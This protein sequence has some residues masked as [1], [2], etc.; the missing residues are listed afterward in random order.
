MNLHN[1]KI[2]A[3]GAKDLAEALRTLPGVPGPAFLEIKVALGSRKDLGRP[4]E[5]PQENK[6]GFM[7]YLQ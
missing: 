1:N 6:K 3:A 5:T 7:D 2:G 4:K